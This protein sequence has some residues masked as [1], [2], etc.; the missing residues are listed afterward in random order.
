MTKSYRVLFLVGIDILLELNGDMG[1][2]II[3]IIIS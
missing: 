1:R 3:R 2:S